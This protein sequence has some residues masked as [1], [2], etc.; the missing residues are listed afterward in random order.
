M[1]ELKARL[2]LKIDTSEAWRTNNPVLLSGESG[3]ESDTNLMK[4]GDGVHAWNEL[5]YVNAGATAMASTAA[6]AMNAMALGGTSYEEWSARFD[7]YVLNSRI[8]AVMST[9]SLPEKIPTSNAVTNW[10]KTQNFASAGD[11]TTWEDF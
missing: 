11:I 5:Q 1:Q 6:V 2:R 9:A 10:V 8:E 3:Y 4:V 7:N